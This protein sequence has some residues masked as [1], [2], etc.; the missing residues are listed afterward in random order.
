MRRS[1]VIDAMLGAALGIALPAANAPRVTVFSG[2]DGQR[3]LHQC[4]RRAPVSSAVWRPT[5]AQVARAEAAL[6]AAYFHLAP[7]GYAPA[8]VSLADL[9]RGWRVEATGVV[10]PGHPTVYLNYIPRGGPGDSASG[11]GP[12]VICDGG[13]GLF[14][15]AVDLVTGD[16][17]QLD[18]NGVG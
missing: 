2:V 15:A 14:G 6:A 7:R 12:T 16:V 3:L 13:P 9:Q 5:L 4:S 8:I 18:F 11:A 10:R 1:A 17:G